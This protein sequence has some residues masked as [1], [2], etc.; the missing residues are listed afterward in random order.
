MRFNR[1]ETCFVAL[2]L[3]L[4][5]PATAQQST[6]ALAK[7]TQNPLA[8]LISIPFQNNTNINVG[9]R[10]GTQNVLNIQP[11]IPIE[12][13]KDWNLITRTIV[14]I[15]TQ[16]GFAA[17]ESSTTGLGDV[18]FTGFLSPSNAEGLIW[19]VG[20]IGQLPTNSS[21][22]LGNDRWGLGPSFVAL[23]LEKGGP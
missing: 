17:G 1:R 9:P 10:D 23:R 20:A 5:A 22:R 21:D 3:A 6:E 7:A 19:G 8:N 14:P 4:A 18:Q 13:R 11:V 12:L 15:I 2:A 16:P